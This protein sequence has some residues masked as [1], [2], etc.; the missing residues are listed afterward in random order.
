M[1]IMT[2]EKIPPTK[3]TLNKA[4]E[5]SDEIIRNI[6]YDEIPLANIAL[7]TVR[8]ARLINDFKMAKIMRYEISGYNPNKKGF[9]P[10]EEW[11]VGIKTNR[12]Y[13]TK[14]YQ[15]YIYPESIEELERE[16]K[17]LETNMQVARDADISFSSAN[18]QQR[19][20]TYQGNYT[21]RANIK[22]R[23]TVVSKRLANRRSL[24]YQYVLNKNLELK[25]SNIA[26]DIFAE[27]REKVD[28]TIGKIIPD[29]VVKFNA[30]YNNLKTENEENWSNAVH[31]CRKILKDLAD[32]IYPPT[33]DI[34]K[35]VDGK[36]KKIE[37]GEERY[38]NRILEFID[39]KSDSESFKSVVGSQLRFIGDRLISI[40]EASHKGSH[41]TIVSKE[42]AN[43]VVV[44]TYL[45]IGD[46]LSLVD[47][48]I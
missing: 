19:P 7:K 5:L 45:L 33:D 35:E 21:E 20:R 24:V 1:K 38:I 39:N 27:I 44:Y 34:E 6:E 30:V 46:I 3:K 13:E 2:E 29:S 4:L 41:T 8:L 40:L 48:K 43:R 23:Y 42:E 18:P 28:K 10:H 22:D 32:S 15:N 12:E 25:Y 26:D 16:L 17:I 31:S 37:L 14:D 11:Q 9:L 47:I 36:L